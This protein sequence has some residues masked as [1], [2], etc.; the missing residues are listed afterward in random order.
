MCRRHLLTER[1]W[2]D[3][4]AA[5]GALAALAGH[6]CAQN[7]PAA[8]HGDAAGTGAAILPPLAHRPLSADQRDH[9][10]PQAGTSFALLSPG[11]RCC[12]LI[13]VHISLEHG[14]QYGRGLD[15]QSC[16]HLGICNLTC[17]CSARILVH[18]S[19]AL[20]ENRLSCDLCLMSCLRAMQHRHSSTLL[21]RLLACRQ[22]SLQTIVG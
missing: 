15:G 5:A 2:C 19:S 6:R 8:G 3:A 4:M 18:K 7:A 1:A 9:R 20:Q 12:S 11:L 21:R 22:K 17:L 14:R 16:R 13:S 10:R